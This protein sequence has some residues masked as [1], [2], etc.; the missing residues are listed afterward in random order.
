MLA[1]A[2][3]LTVSYGA[4]DERRM[5]ERR[6]DPRL[7]CADLV[8]VIWND[9]AGRAWR[10]VANLE[11][12]SLSGVCLQVERPILPGSTIAV[13]YGHGEI[14]GLVR[15]CLFRDIGYFLGIEFDEGYRW[16]SAQFQPKHLMDPEELDL[17]TPAPA[18]AANPGR[19]ISVPVSRDL[20]EE[21]APAA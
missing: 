16:S 12:I 9:E 1:P 3:A 8:E 10:R 7:L 14:S 5:K 13:N 21:P 15:Y 11:D 20:N 2:P 18:V 17:R 4:S 19:T 6:I